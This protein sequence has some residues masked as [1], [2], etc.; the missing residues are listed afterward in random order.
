MSVRDVFARSQEAEISGNGDPHKI[1][2]E[3]RDPRWFKRKHL[4]FRE[5]TRPAYNG[6]LQR[7][8]TAEAVRR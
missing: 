8:A 5:D 1:L 6:A 3:L 4:Q 2:A 7:A